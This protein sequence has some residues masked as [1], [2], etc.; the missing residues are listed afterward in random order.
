VRELCCKGLEWFGIEL[1][2]EK[3]SAGEVEISK[4]SAPVRVFVIKTDEEL[5]IA[6]QTEA[7]LSD[8]R[9]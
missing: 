6:R 7:L 8:T 5:E 4:D 9:L 1:D 2:G 3:N